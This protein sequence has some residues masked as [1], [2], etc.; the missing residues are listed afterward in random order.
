MRTNAIKK[1][2]RK[3]QGYRSWRTSSLTEDPIEPAVGASDC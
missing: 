2:A 3:A 1:N